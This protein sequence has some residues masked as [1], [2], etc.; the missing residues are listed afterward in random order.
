M[1]RGKEEEGK[2]DRQTDRSVTTT[3]ENTTETKTLNIGIEGTGARKSFFGQD[4]VDCFGRC[5]SDQKG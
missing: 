2:T 1:D 5:R 4:S 3:E